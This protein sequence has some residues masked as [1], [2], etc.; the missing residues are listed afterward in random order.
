MLNRLPDLNKRE[1]YREKR[2]KKNIK[3]DFMVKIKKTEISGN[4]K[5]VTI[6]CYGGG[7]T[8]SDPQ[9]AGQHPY[10]VRFLGRQVSQQEYTKA[11]QE[12]TTGHVLL[13]DTGRMALSSVPMLVDSY[14]KNAEKE[15]VYYISNKKTKLY[16]GTVDVSFR[17]IKKEIVMSPVLIGTKERLL[18]AYAGADLSE[19]VLEAVGYSL[20]K[21]FVR[22]QQLPVSEH[23]RCVEESG[24]CSGLFFRYLLKIPFRYLFSGD[25][26]RSLFLKEGRVERHMV[27]RMLL[28]VFAVFSFLYMPYITK[29]YG[30]NGDESVYQKHA[31]YVLDYYLKGDKA[32]LDQPKTALHLYGGIVHTVAE[33]ICQT[34]NIGNYFEARHFIGG[35]IGA[36]GVLFAGLLGLRWGG[37]LCGLMSILLMF[38][39][40]RFLGHSMNNLTDIPFAVG[41]LMSVYF[42]IRLFDYYPCFR[43][44]EMVGLIV[45]VL[46]SLG[47]RSGGLILFPMLFMYAGLFYVLRYGIGEFYK[48]GKY[49]KKIYDILF[50]LVIVVM[51]GYLV[52]ILLWPFALQAPVG[53]VLKSLA[54][55]TNYGT[56]LRTIFAGQQMMSNM[57]PW[58]YAPAYLLIGIPVVTVLG[59][60][61][62]LLYLLVNRK[63]FSLIAYFLLFA[64]VFP[65]FWVVYKNSNLYGGIRHLLFVMPVLVVIAARF[66][67]LAAAC[68]RKAVKIVAVALF[69]VGLSLPALHMARNH[70][71]DYVYFNEFVGGIDG[72]YG[73]YETDYYYNSM[74]NAADWFHKNVE[75]PRDRKIKIVTN[76]SAILSYYFR[77]DTNVQ[78]V[79]SRF[80]EKYSKDWD[81]GIFVNVYINSFQLRNKLFPPRGTIYS[82]DVKGYPM[83]V[84]IKRDT[85]QDLEGFNLEK[86]GKYKESLDVF[87]KYCEAYPASEEVLARM[88]KIYYMLG[89]L[90]KAEECADKSLKLHPTLNET[91]HML[92]LVKIQQKKYPEALQAAQTILDENSSAI[93]GY[94]LRALVYT[95]MKNYKEAI[96]NVNT[97]LNYKPGHD[98]A[99]MLGGDILKLSG[100][101]KAA[102]D[103]YMKLLSIDRSPAN[104]TALADCY[105]HMKDYKQTET[106]LQEVGQKQP[107]FFPMYK[108]LVRM[109]IQKNEL[110]Q[111]A[112]LL[113]QM[114]AINSD[115]ELFVL[116]AYYFNAINNKDMANTMLDNALKLNSENPEAQLLKKQWNAPKQAVKLRV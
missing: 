102:A 63:A 91:L 97:V 53:N 94:Y 23:I 92:A 62:Y 27:F 1:G 71:N 44:R 107:G 56:G 61:A 29:D 37:G 64:A 104:L 99:L 68:S 112:G 67:S 74:K 70:P 84:V 76:H 110:P 36:L 8:D 111:A 33:A 40:P 60:F 10:P 58:Y 114:A 106:L 3:A 7:E 65:V 47:T 13:V 20:Q 28:L 90:A 4:Y 14:F 81:Y 54:Q 82:T 32:A 96:Q 83:S 85:K 59:F 17:G 43:L 80:Y 21:G 50:V 22:L 75:I 55:F 100:N 115:S 51:A 15:N 5:D 31:G 89:N 46:L 9:K 73:D 42:T 48:F 78:I 11:L 93:E 30:V 113:T 95:Q 98:R 86:A 2:F 19:N 116:R 57:L 108:V 88:S 87:N 34:F 49:R 109:M 45:G 24:K 66:W 26:F 101:Y 12:C 38:F 6:L 69:I 35:F 52:S 77:A 18:Q 72:A 39:T 41:Y 103:V 79:Y 25:F 105:C 16:F